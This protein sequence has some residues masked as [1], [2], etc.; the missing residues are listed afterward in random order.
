MLNLLCF[1]VAL[2]HLLS[3]CNA[4]N[5]TCESHCGDMFG[6][7]LCYCELE[8]SLL[9]N[10]Q[11]TLDLTSTF[12]PP[13]ANPPEFVTVVYSFLY[14]NGTKATKDK[15]WYWSAQTSHFLHPFEVFQFLSLFFGK[16]EPYYTGDLKIILKAECGS[17]PSTQ[18]IDTLQLLTQRVRIIIQYIIMDLFYS[19]Y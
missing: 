6:T 15:M 8:D 2:V 4:A 11:N 14:T 18:D 12:F 13:E 16:P 9:A 17:I 3:C 5:S 10:E 19:K 7:C 1:I